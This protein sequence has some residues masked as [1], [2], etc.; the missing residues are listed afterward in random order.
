MNGINKDI[1]FL[2][3]SMEDGPRGQ[4]GPNVT[5]GAVRGA[6]KELELARIPRR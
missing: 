4:P 1:P 2:F 5:P 6:K 3:Q